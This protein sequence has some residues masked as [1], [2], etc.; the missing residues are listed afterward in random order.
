MARKPRMM[1]KKCRELHNII[2]DP[3]HFLRF[4]FETPLL[5]DLNLYYY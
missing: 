5:F 4:N 3:E 1:I 2:F